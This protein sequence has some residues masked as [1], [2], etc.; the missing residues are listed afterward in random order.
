MSRLILAQDLKEGMY[1]W[2]EGCLLRVVHIDNYDPTQK[3]GTYLA[4]RMVT[5]DDGQDWTYFDSD[6]VTPA[7]MSEVEEKYPTSACDICGLSFRTTTSNQGGRC[8][9]CREGHDDSDQT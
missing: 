5:T 6:P 2:R 4:K 3:K 7:D 1:I 8:P 9:S